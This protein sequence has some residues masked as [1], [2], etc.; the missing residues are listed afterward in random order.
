MEVILFGMRFAVLMHTIVIARKGSPSSHTRRMAAR[1]LRSSAR[2]W[3]SERDN[4]RETER[5]EGWLGCSSCGDFVVGFYTG[6][7]TK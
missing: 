4:E 7:L 6:P 2:K 1:G 3:N 5:L